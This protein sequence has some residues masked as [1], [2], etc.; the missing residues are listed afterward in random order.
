MLLLNNLLL[1]NDLRLQVGR[2]LCNSFHHGV[3][4]IVTTTLSCIG[5]YVI[6]SSY[7]VELQVILSSLL[8]LAKGRVERTR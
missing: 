8:C 3:V 5:S 4:I 7:V 1:F 2:P 6:A